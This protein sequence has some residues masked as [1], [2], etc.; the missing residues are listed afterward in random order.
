MVILSAALSVCTGNATGWYNFR[1]YIKVYVRARFT[2]KI[3]INVAVAN[4]T[5]PL[6][7]GRIGE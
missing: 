1:K 2:C 7:G 6:S 4:F 5:F 3:G